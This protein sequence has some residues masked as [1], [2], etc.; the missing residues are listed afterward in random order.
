MG[1][2]QETKNIAIN[3]LKA[4][5]L[6]SFI[7]AAL[8]FPGIALIFKNDFPQF[9]KYPKNSFQKSLWYLRRKNFVRLHTHQNYSKL[10]IT[11]VGRRHLQKSN[12]KNHAILKPAKWDQKWRIILFDIPE[13]LKTNRELFRKKLKKLGSHK[14]QKSI[15][16]HPF[17]CK[18]EILRL[19]EILNIKPFV[20]FLTVPSAELPL[21]IKNNFKRYDVF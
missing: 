1:T 16:V 3:I 13:P 15:Y 12:L 17:D 21:E 19:T 7:A 11:P 6:G 14:L 9:K 20:F 4:L 2:K 18:K 10:E 8:V 5:A